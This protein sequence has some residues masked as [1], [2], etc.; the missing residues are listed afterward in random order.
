MIVKIEP[1]IISYERV[2]Q[3]ICKTPYHGHPRGCPNLGRKEGC[4]PVPLIDKILDL[5]QDV[6]VVYTKFAVGDFAEKMRQ[7]H[8]EWKN[9]RQWYNPRYWQ[10]KARKFQRIEEQKA[11]NKLNLTLILKSPE[12]H[13]V[14]LT[15]LMN[16]IGINLNWAWPPKHEFEKRGYQNNNVY[17]IS[18]GGYKL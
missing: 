8:P 12:A 15:K 4:P 14:N 1:E 18:L 3:G 5:N 9:P 16:A 13:G 7:N 6:Y 10:P 17:L 2:I 11:V